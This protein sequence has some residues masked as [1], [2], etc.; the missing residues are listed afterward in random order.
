MPLAVGEVGCA[1]CCSAFVSTVE[2]R[3]LLCITFFAPQDSRAMKPGKFG[4]D[5]KTRWW[6]LK[7]FLFSPRKLGKISS[8]TNIFQMGWNHQPE[9]ES[10]FSM[11]HF[12]CF[13]ARCGCCTVPGAVLPLKTKLTNC[14]GS[15][16]LKPW[17]CHFTGTVHGRNEVGSLDVY[18]IICSVFI[19]STSQVVGLG[20]SEP[21]TVFLQKHSHGTSHV[22][23]QQIRKTWETNRTNSWAKK[24]NHDGFS[25]SASL[26]GSPRPTIYK[27]MFGETTIFYVK[28][29]NHPIETSIYKWLALGF[30]V[31]V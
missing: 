27:W 15:D 13:H 16:G 7:Y 26:P 18:P 11:V 22:F 20:I 21:S 19:K 28:I 9:E 4:T 23:F 31:G 10:Q 3:D 12:V 5:P 29:W 25:I 17:N 30:Q 1:L 2:T 24:A 6:Q 8:L 14:K